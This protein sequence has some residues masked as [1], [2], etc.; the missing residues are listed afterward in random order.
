MAKGQRR[1]WQKSRASFPGKAHLLRRY[2]RAPRRSPRRYQPFL[3]AKNGASFAGIVKVSLVVVAFETRTKTAGVPVRWK[4]TVLRLAPERKPLPEIVIF[5]PIVALIG[6]TF[7]TDGYTAFVAADAWVAGT[8][9]ARA[10]KSTG[11]RERVMTA[12]WIGR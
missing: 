12:W 4:T 11:L 7:E 5:S 1:L 6:E 2:R 10:A 9:S 3:R 8:A